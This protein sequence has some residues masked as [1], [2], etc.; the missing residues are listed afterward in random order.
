MAIAL[1]IVNVAIA[2]ACLL[3]ARRV[4]TWHRHITQLTRDFNRW[5]ILAESALPEQALA[6][7]QHRT[8]LR[9]WQ[10]IHL[11]W[12]LQQRQLVQTAKVL[13]LAWF[14]SRRG[15]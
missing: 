2:I 12:Q 7:T 4:V 10:L 15:L 8:Q 1:A 13:K 5:T 14:M 9:Q 6:F 3:L 11:K